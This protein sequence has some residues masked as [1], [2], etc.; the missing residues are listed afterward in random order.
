MHREENEVEDPRMETFQK[1]LH[2]E[3]DGSSL[4]TYPPFDPPV[5]NRYGYASIPLKADAVPTR[6]KPFV[7][8]GER[9]EAHKIVTEDW[10]NR[11]YIER[12]VKGNCEWLSQTFVVP[13]KSTTFPWKGVV[14][15]RGTKSQIRRVNCPLPMIEDILVKQGKNEMFS[16]LDLKQAFHQQPMEPESRPITCC[17]TPK[18]VYQWRVN[19]MG[20]ANAS[21]H[22]Q[23]MIE[24]VL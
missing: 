1:L 14:D 12:Q 18:G 7:M 5:R 8:H 21:Q 19:V 17:Y 6:S 23:A 4:G 16:I 13:K 3:F 15:M 10:E 9:Q 20:L 11:G 2:E 24:E 22:F